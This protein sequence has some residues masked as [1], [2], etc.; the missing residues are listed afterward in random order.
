MVHPPSIDAMGYLYVGTNAVLRSS[1]SLFLLMREPILYEL[2]S[3]L[4]LRGMH[5]IDE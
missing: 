2:P 4:V 1:W 5:D 3:F